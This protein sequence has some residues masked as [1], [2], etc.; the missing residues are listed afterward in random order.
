MAFLYVLIQWTWGI[1]QTLLGL[2]ILLREGLGREHFWFHG[3]YVTRWDHS[4]GLSTGMFIFIGNALL[5]NGEKYAYLTHEY[6]HS[7]QSLIFGPLYLPIVG[8]TSSRW[9]KAYNEEKLQ[10]GISYFSVFPE[11]QAN[12]FGEKVTG[13][14]VPEQIP[15]GLFLNEAKAVTLGGV[16]QYVSVKGTKPENPILLFLH[17]GPGST[18]T[19][20]SYLYQSPWEKYYTVVNWDQRCSG[21]TASISGT[22]TQEMITAERIIQDA[23]ELTDYLREKYHKDK[24]ILI[25]HSW[26]T[27]LGANLASRYPEKYYAYIS[28]GT[29]VHSRRE[30]DVQCDYYEKKFTEAGDQKK[31][32]ALKALGST[33][34]EAFWK[35]WQVEGGLGMNKILI[36]EGNSTVKA[37]GMLSAFRHV[38]LPALWSSE[39]K[40]KDSLHLTAYKAYPHVIEKEM[41][42]FDAEKLGLE[43]RIPVYYIEGDQDY[44]TPYVLAEEL[45]EKTVAPD[46]AYYLLKNCAHSWEIDAPEQMAEIMCGDLRERLQK[47]L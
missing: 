20:T 14:K 34:E 26:G 28:T 18:V 11:D 35:E 31:L 22:E 37:T 13:I 10:A 36:K 5:E 30:F 9:A 17:G 45:Y 38:I 47:F 6:G 41:P 33:R 27:Y 42:V 25:G 8:I 32:A 24:I 44:Q 21:K 15:E 29:M 3:A 4:G 2:F 16:E 39:Y 40:L 23:V 43:Y 12:R 19:G 1:I 7:I 46:K